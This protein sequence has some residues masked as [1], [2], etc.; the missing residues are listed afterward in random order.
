MLL[1]RSRKT[2]IVADMPRETPSFWGPA[3]AALV[4]TL[5]VSNLGLAAL[6]SALK[7]YG[8]EYTTVASNTSIIIR[9]QRY[10][11]DFVMPDD[12]IS[13][14]D[15]PTYHPNHQPGV[16]ELMPLHFLFHQDRVENPLE[17]SLDVLPDAWIMIADE[18]SD[19]FDGS[20]N[21]FIDEAAKDIKIPTKL[22]DKRNLTSDG[23]AVGV[24][25]VFAMTESDS[26]VDD[27]EAA[28]MCGLGESGDRPIDYAVVALF[29]ST[30]QFSRSETI[31]RATQFH[32]SV[33][34]RKV[35]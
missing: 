11:V 2:V 21:D 23:L 32:Q 5:V 6:R 7:G 24:S 18:V 17:T 33:R 14:F 8:R 16:D 34:L 27:F 28:V 15:L 35:E 20:M 19:D 3:T 25:V 30:T 31:E 13:A 12:M 1:T 29:S 22:L 4:V 10:E 9:N 26:D